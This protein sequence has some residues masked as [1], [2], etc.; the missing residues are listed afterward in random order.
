[1]R[2]VIVLVLATA[3]ASIAVSAAANPAD[4]H[5]EEFYE[6]GHMLLIAPEIVFDGFP[7]V[8]KVRK[9]V[10]L[11]ANQALPLNAH[12]THVHF[13]NANVALIEHAGNWVFPV[14]PFGQPALGFEVPWEDCA[15]FLAFYGLD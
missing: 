5:T 3:F 2:R 15:S 14:A 1:M 6:H 9:C 4:E 12:H 11:A 10:D 7:V 13:G 8:T